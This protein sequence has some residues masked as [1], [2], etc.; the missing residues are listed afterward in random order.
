MTHA[1]SLARLHDAAVNVSRHLG[2]AVV[3]PPEENQAAALNALLHGDAAG[4]AVRAALAN[5]PTVRAVPGQIR[6]AQIQSR[7]AFR[8][9]CEAIGIRPDKDGH[10]NL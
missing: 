8:A 9:A 2:A 1:E 7:L 5:A 10:H 4:R 3:P 6:F